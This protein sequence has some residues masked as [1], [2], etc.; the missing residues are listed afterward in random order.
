[1]AAIPPQVSEA[2]PLPKGSQLHT[3]DPRPDAAWMNGHCVQRMRA[4]YMQGLLGCRIRDE[5]AGGD[6][7]DRSG[8]ASVISHEEPPDAGARAIGA[9][10]TGACCLRAV[11]EAGGH[12]GFSC[13]DVDHALAA[14]RA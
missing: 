11:G 12:G 5:D 14:L 3:T 13:V 7:G 4:P 9:D 2:P 1:M 6:V 8:L 10:E